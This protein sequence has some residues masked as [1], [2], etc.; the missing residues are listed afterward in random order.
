MFK[1]YKEKITLDKE[2]ENFPSVKEVDNA[3]YEDEALAIILFIYLIT[4]RSDDN[5]IKDFPEEERVLEALEVAF[6]DSDLS[7]EER[8][9]DDMDLIERTIAQYKKD[10]VDKIQKDID[11]YDKKMYQFIDL[12][13]HKDNKPKVIKNTHEITDKVSFSTNI[14]I[15]TTILDNSI[16]IILDKA[17]LV[18]M[19]K[20]GKF[21]GNLRGKLSPNTRSK[22]TIKK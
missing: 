1:L 13:R 4:D 21:N 16:N 12:L 3:F 6:G 20:S 14:E 2:H 5:P 9:A 7:L 17:L 19:K 8:Y 10:N 18:N 15:L 11:L 22:L